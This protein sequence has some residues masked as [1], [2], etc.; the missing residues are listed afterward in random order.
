[1]AVARRTYV[2]PKPPVTAALS[3][4]T[5]SFSLVLGITALVAH[6]WF[7]L[8]TEAFLLVLALVALFAA[9]ALLLAGLAFSR[10]WRF[11]G[12]GGRNVLAAVLLALLVL[13]PFGYG[14][15]LFMTL[16]MLADVTTDLEN[17]PAMPHAAAGREGFMMPLADAT[18][19]RALLQLEAYPDMTGRR[20][21]LPMDRV[22]AIVGDLMDKRG[23][24]RQPTETVSSES[25]ARTSTMEAV[26]TTLILS[27]PADV[28]V[29]VSDDGES[30]Y[31]DMR[32]A[33][34]YGR[35]DL[36]DNAARIA[37]FLVD[38]DQDVA[39]QQGTADPQ[40]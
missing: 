29:R 8:E 6:R 25:G 11:G 32:S 1:M 40:D 12:E 38:L 20:Y 26:A 31:V 5:A 19:G 10:I 21:E 17:P 13:A 37:A 4:S 15:Y 34:R 35:H 30:T 22:V 39:V 36:G 27:I 28:V 33:S 3:R 7:R 24:R 9:L 23:W 16:P 14:A 2:E 18:L